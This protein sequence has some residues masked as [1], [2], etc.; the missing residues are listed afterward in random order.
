ME[1]IF[2]IVIIE[3]SFNI[4][5]RFICI[6]VFIFHIYQT[7]ICILVFFSP[8]FPKISLY[9]SLYLNVSQKFICVCICGFISDVGEPASVVILW[10]RGNSTHSPAGGAASKFLHQLGLD[11]KVENRSTAGEIALIAPQGGQPQNFF[12]NL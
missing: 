2:V 9:F 4:F 11:E 12:I 5:Q 6:L 10:R 7:F 1:I 8:Y 3:F